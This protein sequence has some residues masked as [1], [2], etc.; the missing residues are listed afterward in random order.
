MKKIIL[1]LVALMTIQL[2]ANAQTVITNNYD[3]PITSADGTVPSQNVS[4]TGFRQGN[5]LGVTFNTDQ[6]LYG[7]NFLSDVSDLVYFGFGYKMGFG[8]YSSYLATFQLG[9]GKR[10]VFDDTF[11]IQG[12]IGPY[13]GY[14]SYEYPSYNSKNGKSSTETK[15]EFTYG[16]NASICAGL[17]LWNTKKGN[18]TFITLGYY[19]TAPEFKTENMGDNGAW[20]I[21]FTTIL[22]N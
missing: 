15:D 17:K 18:S 7:L 20:C 8:D 5:D 22:N 13:M 11:L 10:Y 2:G 16:A 9:V 19:M 3:S 4:P 6:K 21:G 12:K 14:N 1:S